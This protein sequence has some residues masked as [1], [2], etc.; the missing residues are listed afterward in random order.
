MGKGRDM[1]RI[2]S[3]LQMLSGIKRTRTEDLT[4]TERLVTAYTDGG[5]YPNPGKGGWGVVLRYKDHVREFYGSEKDTTN[6]RME[7]MAAIRALE[8]LKKPCRVVLH[9]DSQYVV[10]GITEW[11]D[12]WKRQNWQKVKNVDLWKRLDDIR[13]THDVEWIWVR[14][15]DGNP[16][17]ERADQLAT[18][19]R[20]S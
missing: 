4:M 6:N 17:N 9:T 2:R 19:G 10:R 8:I 7:L 16:G 13:K 12:N 18:I 5:C 3:S 14:G 11:I 20:S 1:P 15:H